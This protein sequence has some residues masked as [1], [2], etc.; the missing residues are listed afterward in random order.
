MRRG[1]KKH[2]LPIPRDHLA[3]EW[4]PEAPV[5]AADWVVGVAADWVVR[6]VVDS[7]AMAVEA[8][9]PAAGNRRPSARRPPC[10][11]RL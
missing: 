11:R 1:V 7:V 5:A 4:V 9:A 8:A 2:G 6:A 10:G 3:A